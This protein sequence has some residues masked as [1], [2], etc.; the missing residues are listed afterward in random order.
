MTV[1]SAGRLITVAG[2]D[3]AGKSTLAAALHSAL[4]NAGH[5]A[6]LIG[7]HT[8]EVPADA[9]LSAY[10]DSL[11][12]IV[13]RRDQTVGAACGEHY[14]LFALAAW[15]S[16]QDRLV[17]Q[18]ALKAGTHVILDNSHHKIIA[19]Y[20]ANPSVPPGLARQVFAHLTSADLVL[21]LRISP[22]EALRRKGGFT[23]LEAGR[24]GHTGDAFVSYQ[25]DVSARLREQAGQEGWVPI[26]VTG[27]TP[28][29]VLD[30][31]L[32]SL[33]PRLGFT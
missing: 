14:W 11:N 1:P 32:A 19:R 5:D 9:A 29:S 23:P 33:A 15:Y 6:V 25:D 4:N 16:L 22:G 12:A 17:I 28:G 2:I 18:P 7:K 24:T 30:Q 10:L 21:F 27:L 8:T 31:A 3:G 20:A 13:Y 26:D